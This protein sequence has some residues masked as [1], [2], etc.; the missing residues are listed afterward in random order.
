MLAPTLCVTC[1]SLRISLPRGRAAFLACAY[2][3]FSPERQLAPVTLL[4]SV[5]TASGKGPDPTESR[6]PLCNWGRAKHPFGLI[7]LSCK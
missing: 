3:C 1:L 6:A 7:T 4:C 2:L 5:Y